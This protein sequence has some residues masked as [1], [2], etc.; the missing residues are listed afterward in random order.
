MNNEFRETTL[1]QFG[2][3]TII[4]TERTTTVKALEATHTK[5]IKAAL[6]DAVQRQADAMHAETM[7]HLT[8][9]DYPDP[10]GWGPMGVGMGERQRQSAI[11]QETE[12]YAKRRKNW[13]NFPKCN[14]DDA[15]K[16]WPKV[17][18]SSTLP[19]CLIEVAPGEYIE[20]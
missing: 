2:V 17:R 1:R 20:P 18:S 14:W 19:A 4:R 3:T 11:D 12:R 15:R 6:E 5:A 13:F 9:A 10:D 8:T 7:A 16:G